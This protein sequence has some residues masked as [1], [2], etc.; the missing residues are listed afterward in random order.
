MK[1]LRNKFSKRVRY[2]S[3]LCVCV[4]GLMAIIGT[5][6]GGGG[7]GDGGGDG[8]GT[9]EFSF[10]AGPSGGTYSAPDGTLIVIP[11]GAL[12]EEITISVQTH[13]DMTT[14][15]APAPFVGG[16]LFGPSGITFLA[17][18]TVTFPL[19]Q[20][21][22]PGTELPIYT[23]ATQ[24]GG[25]SYTTFIAT[26]N[27]DMV[28]ATAE[29]THFSDY[30]I[31]GEE[32]KELFG[33]FEAS[34]FDAC[35][36]Q[37]LDS[38]FDQ[39]KAQAQTLFPI[40]DRRA[41]DFSAHYP[42][43]G[44]GCW[45]TAGIQFVLH[46][47]RAEGAPGSWVQFDSKTT[48]DL[49]GYE[50]GYTTFVFDSADTRIISSSSCGEYQLAYSF[51]IYIN[52]APR[53]AEATLEVGA[54]DLCI[55]QTTNVRARLTC[56]G[57]P[58]ENQAVTFTSSIGSIFPDVALFTDQ[59]G[60]TPNAVYSADQEGEA[61]ILGRFDAYTNI[62]IPGGGDTV[63]G[64]ETI[65][66]DRY[67]N[68]SGIWRIDP[69]EQSEQCRYTGQDWWPEDDDSSFNIKISHPGSEESDDI[70]ATYVSN[71]DLVLTGTWD[72]DSGEFN[73][74][75]DTSAIEE[76]GY[77]FYDYDICGDAVDCTL[78]SC[79]NKIDISGSTSEEVDTLEA[80]ST[81]YYSVTFSYA[82][83]PGLPPGQTTWECQ[84]SATQEGEHQ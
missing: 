62:G 36:R 21:Y 9:Q 30:I 43:W 25:W 82:S 76:C 18:V 24:K 48:D 29:I 16:A 35:N 50:G 13:L 23:F 71:T 22:P 81:W 74:F 31:M 52:L 10:R 80:E 20:Q 2:L 37:S 49:V 4:I 72:S 44:Y 84:G 56:G 3:L 45:E 77:M 5:G 7:G 8:G 61:D 28:S 34:F 65:T 67:C 11:P 78:V 15:S 59:N 1:R 51:T 57:E 70:K 79:R 58:F 60:V 6:G 68:M 19:N 47:E 27:I 32:W 14:L 46:A 41:R 66:V 54:S 33:A 53:A 83:G 40:G 63:I 42:Q 26:V 69:I 73:L 38:L 55:G 75:V 17:P 39:F 64:P 12:T